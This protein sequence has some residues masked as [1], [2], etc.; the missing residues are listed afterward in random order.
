[1]RPKIVA[2]G[3]CFALLSEGKGSR[4][5]V[6]VNSSRLLLL[7]VGMAENCADGV[8]QWFS[9]LV[10]MV[11]L[12]ANAALWLLIRRRTPPN[13][14]SYRSVLYGSCLL[15]GLTALAHLVINMVSKIQKM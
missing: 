4:L 3:F 8:H 2:A 6:V 5:L 9:G 12:L 10:S 15:D 7:P 13:M 1:M 11:A 14:A